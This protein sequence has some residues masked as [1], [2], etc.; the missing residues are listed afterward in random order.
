M[1][2]SQFVKEVN[3]H[4]VQQAQRKKLP[5]DAWG[6]LQQTELDRKQVFVLSLADGSTVRFDASEHIGLEKP[7]AAVRGAIFALQDLA[8][9]AT[10]IAK[11]WRLTPDG[12]VEKLKPL[13]EVAL[14][15]T[16]QA[17]ETL[18]DFEDATAAAEEARY[19]PLALP[20][21]EGVNYF[22]EALAKDREVRDRLHGKT[23]SDVETILKKAAG[24]V[25]EERILRAI[26]GD[27]LGM[28]AEI[29]QFA[30]AFNRR[31]VDD[32]DPVGRV[33]LDADA[34]ALDWAKRSTFT[35]AAHVAQNTGV[36]GDALADLLH[37][38]R[39]YPVFGLNQRQIAQAKH[40]AEIRKYREKAV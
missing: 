24:S 1:P 4:A 35:V 37:N 13:H 7:R 40:R 39:G 11:D 18:Q 26:M 9:E 34:A 6:T 21:K 31:R 36:R 20:Y 19:A 32:L 17:Y 23:V 10:P 5:D 28:A 33:K 30:A 38:R 12:K 16:A 8:A 3:D 2:E 22:N 27:P 29:V 14:L 25:A 15:L